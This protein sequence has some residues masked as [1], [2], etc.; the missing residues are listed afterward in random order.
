MCGRY[1]SHSAILSGMTM[2]TSFKAETALHHYSQTIHGVHGP[3]LSDQ[4]DHKNEN[5][6]QRQHNV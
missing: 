4:P 6:K 3:V 2:I 5:K 1:G